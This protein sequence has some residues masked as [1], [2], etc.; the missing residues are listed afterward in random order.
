MSVT[1][2]DPKMCWF[3]NKT[4]PLR[5]QQIFQRCNCERSED[6]QSLYTKLHALGL[7]IKHV[8]ESH[9]Q[10]RVACLR[11]SQVRAKVDGLESEALSVD[12]R[13]QHR[14]TAQGGA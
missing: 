3:E 9:E 6:V 13:R 11:A 12:G 8:N 10:S 5:L 7:A 2:V 14:Q 4:H 1:Q